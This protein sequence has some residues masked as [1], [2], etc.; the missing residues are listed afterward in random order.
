[1]KN[2]L[3]DLDGT[4]LPMDIDVFT[5]GYVTGIVEFMCKNGRDGKVIAN[6][7]LKGVIAMGHNT[8]EV[9]NETVFWNAFKEESG[10][11]KKEIEEEFMLFYETIFDSVDAGVQ[12]PNMIEAVSILKDKGYNLY[13]TTNPLF[14]RIATQKRIQWAG[15][16]IDDFEIVTT[17][18]DFYYCKPSPSYYQEVIDKCGLDI[19]ECMMVGND[20]KEDG[21]VETMGMPVYLVTDYL[22]NKYNLDMNTTYQG[23]S[24]E[25]LEFVKE[26]PAIK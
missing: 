20:V 14:P 24:S 6:S 12:S 21:V 25:F 22:L 9:T 1:M 17:Y 15:L 7:V 4:L 11:D 13:L 18:E 23:T 8:G 16:N 26:L 19:K 5:K 3:F 10:I 2:V